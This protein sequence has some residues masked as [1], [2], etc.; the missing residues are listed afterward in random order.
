M[1][2]IIL[3][4]ISLSLFLGPGC[5]G[6]ADDDGF[7][8]LPDPDPACPDPTS[9]LVNPWRP[10]DVVSTGAVV[11]AGAG[12][13]TIDATAGGSENA[14]DNPYIYIRFSDAGI[15]KAELTDIDAF[16]NIRWA[17][18]L[19]RALI[20]VNGGDSGP[21]G[22]RVAA[23]AA[24]SL[25]AVTELPA[26]AQF[27]EDDWVT[28]DCQLNAGQIGE[29]VT[30]IGTWYEYDVETNRLA[31]SE[32]VYVLDRPD[33]PAIKFSIEGYYS[34]DSESGHYEIAWATL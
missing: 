27:S 31:P 20:R 15:E 14:A 19:K 12:T 16:R 8:E 32:T 10:V 7:V 24:A 1:H 2:R 3:L 4:S 23:V 5:S 17:L 18:A 28:D 9:V 30:A 26:E 34:A 11:S 29:P 6:S 25:D 13:A 21:A 33:G 22:V